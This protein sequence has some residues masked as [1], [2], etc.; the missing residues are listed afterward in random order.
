ME[1]V[2]TPTRA[3]EMLDGGQLI[4]LYKNKL[5]SYTAVSFGR[6]TKIVRTVISEVEDTG[7]HITDDFTPEKALERLGAKN[8]EPSVSG[9]TDPA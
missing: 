3:Q 7:R 6:F 1:T 5:G 4:A 2:Q 9:Q 8:A